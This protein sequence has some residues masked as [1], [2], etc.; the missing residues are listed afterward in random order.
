MFNVT[1]PKTTMSF[2]FK[3]FWSFDS[4]AWNATTSAKNKHKLW[5]LQV[6]VTRFHKVTYNFSPLTHEN[7]FDCNLSKHIRPTSDSIWCF[8]FYMK[9][10]NSFDAFIF[11]FR[12]K[13]GGKN[14]TFLI[15]SLVFFT[16]L[17]LNWS[18]T[19]C[20][21]IIR[22]TLVSYFWYIPITT[23]FIL[24]FYSD[25]FNTEACKVFKLIIQFELR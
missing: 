9:V 11:I 12:I 17:Q 18:I 20:T 16:I 21:V 10:F 7:F 1:V 5:K 8:I 22:E 3:F 25:I 6:L 24:C 14:Q 23:N 19:A 4:R 15:P 13:C 2:P